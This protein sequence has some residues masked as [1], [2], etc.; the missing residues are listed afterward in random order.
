[1]L[2]ILRSLAWL[3]WRVL[4][5][6][7]TRSGAR[8]VIERLSRA[9]ESVLPLAI[10]V[11]MTP[12]AFA[13]GAL[14]VWTG[15]LGA[16][17]PVRAAF[18]L[19]IVRWVLLVILGLAAL[20][21]ALLS[22]GPPASATIRLLLLPIPTRVLYVAHALGA[23]ADPWV[24]LSIPLLAGIAAGFGLRGAGA[25]A[26]LAAAAGALMLLVLLGVAA[27]SGAALQL[28]VRDRRRAELAVLV[29]MLAIVGGSLLPSLLLPQDTPERPAATARDDDEI[30][31]PPW[32]S[33]AARGIPSE[34]Y[35]RTLHDTSVRSSASAVAGAAA[36][37]AWGL[38]AHGLTWPLYRRVLQTPAT[39]GRRQRGVR[40]APRVG[41]I[42]GTRPG[43]SAVALAFVRLALR[44]PRGRSIVLMP[45]VMLVAFAAMFIVRAS[46]F[47]L[48]PISVGGGYSLG[49][50]GIVLAMMSLGPI[51]FNQFA[52][53]G[54]GLTLEFLAPVTS[55]ELLHGKAI[56]GALIAA[57]PS[58]LA[59]AAGVL[60]GGSAAAPWGAIALGACAA[61]V[62]LA[63]VGAV[64][65]MIFPRAVDLSSIGQASNAHQ[66]AGLLGLLA[67]AVA[68]VPPVALSIA[69]LR[70]LDSFGAWL[71][72]MAGWLFIAWLLST[73]GFRVAERILEERRENL[74]MVAQ[75]R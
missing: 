45:V 23:L 39:S 36:L 54:A 42:P 61:Y 40:R 16:S 58:A 27:L 50:F 29:A 70:F 53:D 38:A 65:S 75:G 51:G 72:L 17:D 33:V 18:P 57:I 67:F 15:M 62:L 24:F 34:I 2:R 68:S 52:V 46:A 5:N 49:I 22:S 31:L 26:L 69:A 19:A 8:D 66:A 74:A 14:G 60:T 1:M 13:L 32:A 48:G 30:R 64:L 35:V 71:A 63:P 55:R 59:I 73:A 10:V 37:L 7:L 20:G 6:A 11:L 47:P 21:P 12:A 3:R 25:A 9:A 28:L 41:M 56:G 44:T 43:T 4:V